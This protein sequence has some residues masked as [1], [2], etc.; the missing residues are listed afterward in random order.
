M[1]S[2]EDEEIAKRGGLF[3]FF[4]A[5]IVA[6]AFLGCPTSNPSMFHKRSWSTLVAQFRPQCPTT[7]YA[8]VIVLTSVRGCAEFQPKARWR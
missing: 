7:S 4:V 6:R 3:F 2:G 5:P 1:P 8:L